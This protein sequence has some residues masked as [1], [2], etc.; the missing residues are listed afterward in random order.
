MLIKKSITLKKH[1]TSLSLEIEFWKAL[2][3][4]AENNKLSIESLIAKIDMDRKSSLASST[5]VFILKYFE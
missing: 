1:R 4:I 3:K 5:R 2:N